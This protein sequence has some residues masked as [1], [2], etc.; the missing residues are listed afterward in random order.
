M[1]IQDTI[2]AIGDCWPGSHLSLAAEPYAA[3]IQ[4]IEGDITLTVIVASLLLL[5][6]IFN[7]R[8]IHGIFCSFSVLTD[9][10]K[11]REVFNEHYNNVS[12]RVTF[13]IC[14]PLL[15]FIICRSGVAKYGFL[16]TLAAFVAY[17]LFKQLSFLIIAWLWGQK[18]AVQTIYRLN[19]AAT[20]MVALTSLPVP[21]ILR[22][23]PDMAHI[24]V[25]ICLGAIF[26]VWY[27]IYLVKSVAI[28]ISSGFSHF[29]GFLY[30]CGLELLPVILLADIAIR[31]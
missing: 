28:F 23:M 5:L 18:E 3:P 16:L 1:N 10:R 24:T 15:S 26:L 30:L 17:F 6:I 19:F 11:I 4:H 14:L 29:L 8:V 25:L 27:L 21:V 7:R 20:I 22:F 13:L 31:F 2:R 12:I 9:K